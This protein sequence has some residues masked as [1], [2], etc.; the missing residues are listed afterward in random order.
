MRLL[1]IDDHKMFIDGLAESLTSLPMITH[2]TIK[3]CAADAIEHLEEGHVYQLI[4]LDLNMPDINGFGFMDTLTDRGFH[5]PVAVL[6]GSED[7]K[8]F[9]K[10]REYGISGYI[11][12]SSSI[13][14]LH[15]SLIDISNGHLVL[16]EKYAIYFNAD[17]EP[18]DAEKI[19][20]EH[21]IPRRKLEII[22]CM[23]LGMTNKEIAEKL[24]VAKSTIDGHIKEIYRR[25][26]VSNRAEC[27][28]K[29]KSIGLI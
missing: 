13:D 2:T 10:L 9:A 1:L 20:K 26:E 6:S 28:S 5:F 29:S 14:E 15:Q 3:N 4:M 17:Y 8:D 19:A 24:F 12:K 23:S 22:D 21:K 11:C 27:I 18:D 25:L 16:P 7:P